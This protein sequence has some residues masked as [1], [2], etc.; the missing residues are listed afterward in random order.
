LDGHSAGGLGGRGVN[1]QIAGACLG[2]GLR[3][4]CRA[5]GRQGF[6]RGSL[7]GRDR[8]GRRLGHPLPLVELLAQLARRFTEMHGAVL[9][10]EGLGAGDEGFG[11]LQ[12]TFVHRRLGAL[13]EF[14][15]C[16]ASIFRR[17]GFLSA[18]A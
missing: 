2:C 5:V 3:R 14:I 17:G 4:I 18:L 9:G 10:L 7:A 15:G 13:Q 8:A 6:G 16:L 1:L 12:V 11:D